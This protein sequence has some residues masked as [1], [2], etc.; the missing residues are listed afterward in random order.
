MIRTMIHYMIVIQH[1]CMLD[2][3]DSILP[4][5]CWQKEYMLHERGTWCRTDWY[6]DLG[7]PR[8]TMLD[9]SVLKNVQQ[10]EEVFLLMFAWHDL[11]WFCFSPVYSSTAPAM[12]FRLVLRLTTLNSLDAPHHP[13]PLLPRFDSQSFISQNWTPREYSPKSSI[14]SMPCAWMPL[15][16]CLTAIA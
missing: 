12:F 1:Y 7:C 8:Q 6:I 9:W 11:H 3:L 13:L 5:T 15:W 2:S 4:L 16:L 10:S 14:A